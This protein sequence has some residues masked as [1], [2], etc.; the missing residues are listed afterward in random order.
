MNNDFLDTCLFGSQNA[1]LDGQI[2]NIDPGERG[3]LYLSGKPP[4]RLRSRVR[5][6]DSKLT[7]Y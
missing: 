1:V 3:Y 6:Q 2:L 5:I 4:R 7:T